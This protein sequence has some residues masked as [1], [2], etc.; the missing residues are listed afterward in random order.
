MTHI[1]CLPS[2]LIATLT[3]LGT[4]GL[5]QA[6]PTDELT[7]AIQDV[8]E[9]FKVADKNRDGV[10]TRA[11]VEAAYPQNVK[12]FDALDTAKAG[13]LTLEQILSIMKKDWQARRDAKK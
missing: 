6:Q 12:D 4:A 11:E 5:A 13:K 3:A 2:I 8:T 1:P 10:V 7:K 9:Q